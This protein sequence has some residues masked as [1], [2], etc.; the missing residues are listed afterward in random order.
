MALER[1]LWDALTEFQ[2]PEDPERAQGRD[3]ELAAVETPLARLAKA[4][5]PGGRN[6]RAPVAEMKAPERRVVIGPAQ[7]TGHWP[8]PVTTRAVRH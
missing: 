2:Q 7:C 5:S 8:L 1:G 4:I 3:D 6:P